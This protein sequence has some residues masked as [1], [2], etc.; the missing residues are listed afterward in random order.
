MAYRQLGRTGFMIS[1]IVMGGNTISPTN[2]EH[3]LNYLDTAPAY[4]RT[5]SELGYAK[6]IA[7][8]PRDKFFLNTKISDWDNNRNKLYADIYASLPE[9][10]QK[11]LKSKANEEIERRKAL[12]P[13]YFCHYFRGQDTELHA[14]ALANAMA[15]EYGGKIDRQKNYKQLI[16]DSFEASL[17]RLGTDHTDLLM[18]PHGACTPYEV[19]NHHEI[20]EA[21]EKLKK[22]GKVRYLGLSAHNDPGGVLEAVVKAKVYS[23]AMVAYNI[24]N[25]G[26]VDAALASAH[27]AGL[28]VIAMKAAK[29]LFGGRGAVG[30]DD[31][32]R[33]KLVHDA[34][35]G[36]LKVPQKAYL[37]NLRNSNLSGVISEL[38]TA[39]MVEDNLPLAA[40]KKANA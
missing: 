12:V 39:P 40:P 28:G 34:V 20:F 31:P 21:F 8:R 19:L 7:S 22:D 9:S 27:K 25:H 13:D 3:G 4:G 32:A 16:F 37:W 6:V 29:P 36:P 5:Q 38:I 1:E 11:R 17:K 33:Q 23:V 10:D 2:Y 30:P 24:V 15:K 18:C 26:Y 35:P 14:A